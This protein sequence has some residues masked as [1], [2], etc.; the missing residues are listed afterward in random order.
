MT[1]GKIT[2]WTTYEE[3]RCKMSSEA[4]LQ[5]WE[6]NSVVFIVNSESFNWIAVYMYLL[7]QKKSQNVL[8]M[9]FTGLASEDKLERLTIYAS[10][11]V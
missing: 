5:K 7:S 1:E 2:K 11:P 6:N 3:F 10:Y 8:T 9:K 4:H